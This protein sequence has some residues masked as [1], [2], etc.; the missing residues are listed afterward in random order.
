MK[1]ID[2]NIEDSLEGKPMPEIKKSRN[3]YTN[4]FYI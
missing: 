2:I 1:D 4:D 3:Y